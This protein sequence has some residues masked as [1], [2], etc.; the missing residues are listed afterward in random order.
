LQDSYR[1]QIQDVGLGRP[2]EKKE[3][4]KANSDLRKGIRKGQIF[5]LEQ[6][7]KTNISVSEEGENKPMTKKTK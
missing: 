3:L 1:L 2:F 6:V 4:Q 5:G 7:E